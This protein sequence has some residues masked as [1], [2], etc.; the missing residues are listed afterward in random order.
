[1]GVALA[2]AAAASVDPGIAWAASAASGGGGGGGDTRSILDGLT[3]AVACCACA[4]DEGW[5]ARV[6]V[7]T[8]LH[9]T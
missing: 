5:N 8:H 1:M 3:D 6:R 2:D 4:R 7:R 9:L